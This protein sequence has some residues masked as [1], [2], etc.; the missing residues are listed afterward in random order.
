MAIFVR[1]VALCFGSMPWP[2][3]A[4]RQKCM[5]VAKPPSHYGLRRKR[6]FSCILLGSTA[7]QV[8]LQIVRQ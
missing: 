7:L 5:T 1:S 3:L 6:R 4:M 2:H 8:L